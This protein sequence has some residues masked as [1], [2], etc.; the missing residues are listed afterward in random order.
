MFIPAGHSDKIRHNKNDEA[1]E[2]GLKEVGKICIYGHFQ[3]FTGQE[4]LSNLI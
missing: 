3:D 1:M 4:I 2:E